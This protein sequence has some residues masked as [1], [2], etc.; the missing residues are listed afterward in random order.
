MRSLFVCLFFLFGYFPFPLNTKNKPFLFRCLILVSFIN[1]Y[2]YRFVRHTILVQLSQHRS[3][4]ICV[5]VCVCV[6]SAANNNTNTN[7]R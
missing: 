2:E 1:L 5:S 3:D 4:C 6:N 7:H